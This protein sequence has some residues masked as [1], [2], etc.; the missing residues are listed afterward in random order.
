[1][2][3]FARP[4]R[5]RSS[6]RSRG[7]P[8]RSPRPRRTGSSARRS[9]PAASRSARLASRQ[10]PVTQSTSASRDVARAMALRTTASPRLSKRSMALRRTS[11]HGDERGAERQ[12][13]APLSVHDAR[14]DDGDIGPLVEPS[15][16]ADRSRRGGT[17]V[18]G[19]SSSTSSLPR[20][21]NT[22]IVRAREAEIPCRRRSRARAG[23]ARAPS[24]ARRRSTR[25]PRRRSRD[26]WPAA[27]SVSDD[28]VFA[29]SSFALNE[30]MMMAR[31]LTS[32]AA[33]ASAAS[34]ARA[35]RPTGTW[36]ESPAPHRPATVRGALAIVER[37]PQRRRRPATRRVTP[38]N[39]GV[40]VHLARDG[41]VE[42]DGHRARG[43]RLER[44]QPEALVLGQ[45][46]E[47]RRARRTAAPSSASAT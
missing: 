42:H 7:S 47:D 20:R 32:V 12:L 29:R 4:V 45:E 6:G 44:R 22:K 31:R 19:L 37:R 9:R 17:T 36:T 14:A 5:T 8:R 34:V 25:C 26:W 3:D 39:R 35:G 33:S 38:P 21:A 24:P 1:M 43:Q 16:P 10:A 15:R 2:H 18:S 46:R 11:R 30:T 13:R 23:I 28:S 40:A 41:R 27:P